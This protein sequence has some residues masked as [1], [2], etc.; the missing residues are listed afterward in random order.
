MG[1]VWNLKLQLQ[2]D[3]AGW[4]KMG[5]AQ[6]VLQRL[7]TKHL[8]G[9]TDDGYCVLQCESTGL[10][11]SFKGQCVGMFS[12]AITWTVFGTIL[13]WSHCYYAG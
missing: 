2:V 3:E 6:T 12:N 9:P 1:N 10:D 4:G 5:T 11:F 7:I 8:Q 13:H